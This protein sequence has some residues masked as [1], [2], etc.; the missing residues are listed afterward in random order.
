MMV[1]STPTSTKNRPTERLTLR[2]YLAMLSWLR[3][4]DTAA[5][6]IDEQSRDDA[7]Q[8]NAQRWLTL[9]TEMFPEM[10]IFIEKD[11]TL[12]LKGRDDLIILDLFELSDFLQEALL[13]LSWEPERLV[14]EGN[15]S[16]EID[17][18]NECLA[19]LWNNTGKKF[20]ALAA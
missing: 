20:L 1:C 16:L 12:T 7:A 18:D 13:A 4:G 9:R 15:V 10:G 5:R 14:G 17:Y 6:R 2:A 19:V 8:K 3:I 11:N